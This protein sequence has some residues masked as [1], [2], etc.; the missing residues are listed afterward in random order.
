M[1]ITVVHTT[2]STQVKSGPEQFQRLRMLNRQRPTHNWCCR[3]CLNYCLPLT[4][5]ILFR[6]CVCVF[7]ALL[8]LFLFLLR[9]LLLLLLLLWFPNAASTRSATISTIILMS[10]SLCATYG[11]DRLWAQHRNPPTNETATTSK[12]KTKIHSHGLRWVARRV[13]T[14]CVVQFDTDSTS[15]TLART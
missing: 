1:T 10:R 15:F 12:T 14:G 7:L 13:S 6:V 8:S 11:N 5:F 9:T 3:C 2:P 4:I